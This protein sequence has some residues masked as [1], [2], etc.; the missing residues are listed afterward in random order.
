MPTPH[1]NNRDSATILNDSKTE[2]IQRTHI[3]HHRGVAKC[4]VFFSY[5]KLVYH[6]RACFAHDALH[7]ST[8][9]GQEQETTTDINLLRTLMI[10]SSAVVAATPCAYC[11][12]S[13]PPDVQRPTT[14][15]HRNPTRRS[16]SVPATTTTT[17]TRR[18]THARAS[19]PQLTQQRAGVFVRSILSAKHTRARVVRLLVA[20]IRTV[21]W[22]RW[23]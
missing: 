7:A 12:T 23:C 15:P 9:F 8:G 3:D 21:G 17:T 16:P 5:Y 4:V 22:R 2:Q 6:T 20:T 13:S 1:R 18:P 14:A 11:F 10:S 19:R